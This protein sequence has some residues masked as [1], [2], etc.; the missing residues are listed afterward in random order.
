[1][2][3]TGTEAARPQAEQLLRRS[4]AQ[5][6]NDAATLAALGYEEQIQGDIR[7]AQT[8]Y[9]RAL[10]LDPDLID[11]T[12]NLGVIEAQRG[13][14]PAAIK[15]LQGAFERAPGRSA[16]GMNLARVFCLAG[17]L[18]EARA[19]VARVLEFNPDMNAAKTFLRELKT[20]N[21]NCNA[22]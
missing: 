10:A 15:L 20:V 7:G 2:A 5:F 1:L 9:Q 11:A 22:N 21:P 13:T 12:T 3:N 6:P 4:V 19:S 8:L 17:R 14:L 18:D 16:V